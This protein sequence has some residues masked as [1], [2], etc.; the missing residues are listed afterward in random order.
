[1][2]DTVKVEL[3]T[4]M[5]NKGK[6]WDI[7]EVSRPEARNLLI[8]KGFARMVDANRLRE[9]EAKRKREGDVARMAIEEVYALRNTL[10]G[11][12]LSFDLAGSEKKVFGWVG[13]KEIL[14]KLKKDYHVTLEKKHIKLST[15][16]RLKEIGNYDVV[17][18]LGREVYIKMVVEL[19]TKESPHKK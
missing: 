8:P 1:M 4:R 3:L 9:I 11:K 18:N 15:G 12:T 16:H 10:H 5:A 2:S 17:I 14:D 7:I 19:R 6:P 13:E